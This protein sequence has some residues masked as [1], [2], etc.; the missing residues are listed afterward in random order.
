MTG[1]G[2]REQRREAAQLLVG[3]PPR[4]ETSAALARAAHDADATVADWAAVGAVRLG[5]V[6]ARASVKAL[7][8]AP[9]ADVAQALRVRAALAL[10]GV[11]EAS[12]VPVLAGA[13]EHAARHDTEPT[14]VAA[15][16]DAAAALEA[17]PPAPL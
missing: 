8:D 14:V 15:A 5:D 10:A 11:G 12:G 9:A 16:R 7:V 3:L 17:R 1:Q 2:P 6:P 4:Q 13:L